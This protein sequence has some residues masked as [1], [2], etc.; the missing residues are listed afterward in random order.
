MATTPGHHLRCRNNQCSPAGAPH[1]SHPV[2]ARGRLGLDG[3]SGTVKGLRSFGITTRYTRLVCTF[4]DFTFGTYLARRSPDTLK[5]P[6]ELQ[7]CWWSR[8]EW[9]QPSPWCSTAS[10]DR[11]IPRAH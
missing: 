8:L 9:N 10:P 11:T 3:L 4:A 7:R 6:C 1:H 5:T 2:G